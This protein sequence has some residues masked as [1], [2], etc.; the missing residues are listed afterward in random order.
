[1]RELPEEMQTVELPAHLMR[2]TYDWRFYKPEKEQYTVTLT[3]KEMEFLG[4][5]IEV[6][7]GVM[8]DLYLKPHLET[9]LI[10]WAKEGKDEGED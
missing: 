6:Y 5:A 4:H 7:D 10:K 2:Q 9:A 1:M 3:A 8:F